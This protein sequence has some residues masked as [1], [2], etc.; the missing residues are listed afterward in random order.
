M[1]IQDICYSTLFRRMNIC[2][3]QF[4]SRSKTVENIRRPFA[5]HSTSAENCRM[6][7]TKYWVSTRMQSHQKILG[8]FSPE[9]I[10]TLGMI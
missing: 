10:K 7:G 9:N 4:F 8:L 2:F 6:A 1:K 5:E 3:I